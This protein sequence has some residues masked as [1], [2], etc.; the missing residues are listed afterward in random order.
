MKSSLKAIAPFVLSG[1]V[2]AALGTFNGYSSKASA[3]TGGFGLLVG[4]VRPCT[5]K[6]FDPSPTDPLIVIL[7]KDAVTYDTYNISADV[8][9]TSYHFDVPVG[10]YELIT[11]WPKSRVFAVVVKF[12]KTSRVNVT[13]SCGPFV[14]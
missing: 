3:S 5:A 9:T 4:N 1:L 13:V 8:G 14:T 7:T 6:Q 11:T 2:I 12:G 10:H